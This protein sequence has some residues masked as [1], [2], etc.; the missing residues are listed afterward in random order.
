MTD[1]AMPRRPEDAAPM[2]AWVWGGALL[3]ASVVLQMSTWTMLQFGGPTASG[4]VA[5]VAQAVFAA[6]LLLFAFGWLGRGSVV[7]RRP[8]GIAA[9]VVLAVFPLAE[10][11]LWALVLGIL[12]VAED[13]LPALGT[14]VLAA[15][16]IVAIV[17]VAEIARAGVVPRPWNGAPA[18]GL[19]LVAG[20]SALTQMVGVTAAPTGPT[21][22]FGL[23]IALQQ[24]VGVVVPVLLGV[25]AIVLGLRPA[26]SPAPRE[27]VQV[28]PPG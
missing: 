17:A 6:A 24:L 12:A 26:P 14:A 28:Y 11:L 2:R 20:V 15:Q 18:L 13:A 25:L 9:I 22:W 19:T 10:Q 16:L 3:V 21:G 8:L 23:L 1:A 4:V 7:A 27:P 5:W